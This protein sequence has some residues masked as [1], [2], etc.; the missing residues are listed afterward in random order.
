MKISAFCVNIIKLLAAV[1]QLD[2][3][4][5]YEPR[6]HEF[7]SCRLHQTSGFPDFSGNFF[8]SKKQLNNSILFHEKSWGYLIAA[9]IFS[10]IE[11]SSDEYKS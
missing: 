11:S 7:E 9:S 1:A 8:I 2:R 4:L 5:G 3:V 10:F 6:G